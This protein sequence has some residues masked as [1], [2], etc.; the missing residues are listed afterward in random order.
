MSTENIGGA[1]GRGPSK[2]PA[3][4]AFQFKLDMESTKERL[5][6][7]RSEIKAEMAA[8]LERERIGRALLGKISD[9]ETKEKL[10]K[11][12]EQQEKEW[13][14]QSMALREEL[15]SIEKSMAAKGIKPE[16]EAPN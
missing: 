16:E 9:S 15:T 13:G 10:T 4:K 3:E 11:I 12:A 2:A 6:T 8:L 7:R 5:L 14:R 1:A